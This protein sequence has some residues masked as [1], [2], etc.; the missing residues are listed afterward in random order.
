MSTAAIQQTARISKPSGNQQYVDNVDFDEDA[1]G[2]DL[3][4]KLANKMQLVSVSGSSDAEF[5]ANDEDAD[6]FDDLDEEIPDAS[7]INARDLKTRAGTELTDIINNKLMTAERNLHLERILKLMSEHMMLAEL[8]TC[9]G[10]G[11]LIDLLETDILST[12]LLV[13]RIVSVLML[14]AEAIETMCTV[15]LAATLLRRCIYLGVPRELR[16][17]AAAVLT[18]LFKC[19]D[20]TR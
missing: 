18:Q 10:Y 4:Q 19:S 11:A 12:Q 3:D 1:F 7:V 14:Y 15:G 5:E 2:D 20:A 13:I 9:R 8:S 17:A 16:H 6:P